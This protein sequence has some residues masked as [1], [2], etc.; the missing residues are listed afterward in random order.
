MCHIPQFPSR[1]TQDRGCY[2]TKAG[3]FTEEEFDAAYDQFQLTG[4]PYVYTY[5]HAE[6]RI[7]DTPEDAV[8]SLLAFKKK[9][10]TLGHYPT[11]YR[12]TED[13]K[14]KLDSQLDKLLSSAP[15][16]SKNYRSE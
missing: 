10:K 5:F 1:K 2:S 12:N 3:K 16:V 11:L 6:A 15:K 13:L 4:R 8:L 14:L 7:G 9:L